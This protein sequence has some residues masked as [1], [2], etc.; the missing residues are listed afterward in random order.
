MPSRCAR[1]TRPRP[2]RQ[3][4]K[5]HRRSDEHAVA[6]HTISNGLTE[7]ST[8]AAGDAVR[9]IATAVEAVL[10]DTLNALPQ[11]TPTRFAFEITHDAKNRRIWQLGR[12]SASGGSDP[13]LVTCMGSGH[14]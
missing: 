7:R 10:E 2:V 13:E 9:T 3:R 8:E 12:P 14:L 1:W 5:A 4:W 11:I 6:P